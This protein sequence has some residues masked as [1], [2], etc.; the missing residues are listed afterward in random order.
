[1]KVGIIGSGN[2]GSALARRIIA[3]GHEVALTSKD[4]NKTKKVAEQID[5]RIRAVPLARAADGVDLIIAA[6]PAN[7]QINALQ[8][9]GDLRGKVVLEISNPIK[10]DLSGLT[11][12]FTT[13]FAEEFAKAFPGTKVVK[14]F[15]TVFSQ[16][17]NEGPDFGDGKRAAVLYA[18][19]DDAKQVVRELIES[20]GF[21]AIDAGP[22]QNARY[23]EPLGMLNIWFGFV[24]KRGTNISPTWL[25][26]S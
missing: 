6:T 25:H 12:G 7:V 16:V 9:V 24:A 8:K 19:D 5:S 26:R 1:M 13:S 14:A 17:L 2:M 15:N 22:L 10:P 21:E 3:A 18:G 4:L 20:M 11:V 23:L